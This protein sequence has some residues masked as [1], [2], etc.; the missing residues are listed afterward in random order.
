MAARTRRTGLLRL[1]CVVACMSSFAC[2][3]ASPPTG[4][5]APANRRLVTHRVE[6]VDRDGRIRGD[7]SLGA[8]F[9]NG[10]QLRLRAAAGP[11]E[12]ECSAGEAWS[13]LRMQGAR[14]RGASP[15]RV[16]VIAGHRRV[17]WSLRSASRGSLALDVA[18]NGAASVTA[19]DGPEGEE[20]ELWRIP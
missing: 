12:V 15:A 7:I 1:C 14:K 11:G 4:S 17:A 2:A 20:E 16:E 10:S 5:T 9:G 8:G 3:T 6:L 13:H 19:Q 18:Q